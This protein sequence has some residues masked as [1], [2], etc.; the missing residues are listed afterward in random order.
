MVR[1]WVVCSI[2]RY[3]ITLTIQSGDLQNCQDL[4]LSHKCIATVVLCCYPSFA[5]LTIRFFSTKRWLTYYL[6]NVCSSQWRAIVRKFFTWSSKVLRA[7]I[8]VWRESA[9][10]TQVQDKVS[11]WN[12]SH[13]RSIRN[14]FPMPVHNQL[15]NEVIYCWLNMKYCKGVYIMK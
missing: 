10:D 11:P 12:T 9:W 4:N 15:N 1:Y 2:W 13:I 3:C 7:G 5:Q 8:V 14:H 6:L